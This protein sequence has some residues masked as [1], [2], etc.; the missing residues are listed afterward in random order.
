MVNVSHEELAETKA[1]PLPSNA[2]LEALKEMRDSMCSA[3]S[4]KD[5]KLQPS[6]RFLR[7]VMSP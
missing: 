4:S 6:Q 5:F 3:S 7:R 2:S 1:Q